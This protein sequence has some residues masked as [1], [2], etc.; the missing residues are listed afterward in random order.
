[1][2]V[3]EII[4][5]TVSIKMKVNHK[6]KIVCNRCMSHDGKI[7]TNTTNNNNSSFECQWQKNIC[8]EYENSTF[9]HFIFMFMQ[10]IW[11]VEL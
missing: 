4:F 5:I 1:M 9:S 3:Y 10:I 6:V 11:V 7:T 8:V 2:I